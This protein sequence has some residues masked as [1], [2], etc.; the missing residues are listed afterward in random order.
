MN[1]IFQPVAL[2]KLTTLL[3]SPRLIVDTIFFSSSVPQ[4]ST[5]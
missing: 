1:M 2:Y 5:A 4:F 3:A